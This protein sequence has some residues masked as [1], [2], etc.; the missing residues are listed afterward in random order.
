MHVD[1]IPTAASGH[2]IFLVLKL[3]SLPDGTTCSALIL[4]SVGPLGN[5]Q[6]W[7]RPAQASLQ[8]PSSALA[9][10]REVPA[11]GLVPATDLPQS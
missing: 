6:R 11:Q 8:H 3:A 9:K 10:Q 4:T 7:P 2:N 1:L 5:N